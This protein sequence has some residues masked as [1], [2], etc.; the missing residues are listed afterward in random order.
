MR[1]P[2]AP[3][4]PS[5]NCDDPSRFFKWQFL[6]RSAME[7]R[8]QACPPFREAVSQARLLLSSCLPPCPWHGRNSPPP[9]HDRGK[10]R[11]SLRFFAC[12]AN[13]I[14]ADD[15]VAAVTGGSGDDGKKGLQSL[16]IWRPAPTRSVMPVSQA[17]R[18]VRFDCGCAYVHVAQ[19]RVIPQC[20]GLR[21]GGAFVYAVR[22]AHATSERRKERH[23]ELNGNKK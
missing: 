9:P 4:H 12:M 7:S 1:P 18:I 19:C 15:D 14:A 2:L 21:G 3:L 10:E 11:R 13:P 22:R 23:S 6:P 5:E 8:L 17:L 20:L 16:I